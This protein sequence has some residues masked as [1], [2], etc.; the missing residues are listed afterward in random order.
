M[1]LV[2]F[3]YALPSILQCR[4][5]GLYNRSSKHS[6]H[7]YS[8]SS[9]LYNVLFT[10]FLYCFYILNLTLIVLFEINAIKTQF[11][12][13][14][15]TV[16]WEFKSVRLSDV[17]IPVAKEAKYL[18]IIFNQKL[19]STMHIPNITY[20]ASMGTSRCRKL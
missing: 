1:S 5:V 4:R 13:L 8:S 9:L 11:L 18:G 19:N 12:T 14:A 20:K 3:N 2:A 17:E 15:K 16:L 6:F 7:V 10:A